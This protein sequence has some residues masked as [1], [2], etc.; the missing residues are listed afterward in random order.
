LQEILGDRPVPD[1]GSDEWT[2]RIAQFAILGAELTG[3]HPSFPYIVCEL[4]T[5]RGLS[6][7]RE[8]CF[9][10]VKDENEYVTR[11]RLQM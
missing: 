6:P 3:H 10:A 4:E 11:G 9:L 1:I 8:L 5:F 7:A 2:Q